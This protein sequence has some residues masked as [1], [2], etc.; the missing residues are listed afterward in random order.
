MNNI[1]RKTPIK[2]WPDGTI[3]FQCSSEMYG[4]TDAGGKAVNALQSGFVPLG[5]GCDYELTSTDKINIRKQLKKL[6]L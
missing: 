6:G 1:K 2:V 5:D 3:S 4:V